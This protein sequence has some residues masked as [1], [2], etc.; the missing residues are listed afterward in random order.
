MRYLQP[1]T[2]KKSFFLSDI[3]HGPFFSEVRLKRLVQRVNNLN[4]DIIFL[5]GDYVHRSPKYIEPCFRQLKQLK[6]THGIYG[7]LG[8]HDHWEGAALTQEWMEKAGVRNLDNAGQW[9]E[10]KGQQIRVGGVGDYLLGKPDVRPAI[11]GVSKSGFTI[12]ITHN[13]DVMEELKTDR[14]DL[15]FA[16]HT[17]GGQVTFCGLWAPLIPSK[18][19]QK[20][21]T[22]IIE[23]VHTKL[24]I[25]H[26]VGTVTPPV[27]IFA[28]PQII[29]AVLKSN[30]KLK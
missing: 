14:I 21:R 11:Q 7:V 25:S 10:A 8:N 28:R 17:H 24:I 13:P 12:L 18:Y 30:I 2:I 1:F 22:G 4:P 20:Y 29:I 3:H 15:A 19:G 23:T 5:G 9:V 6:A 27:R 26:G 16:G